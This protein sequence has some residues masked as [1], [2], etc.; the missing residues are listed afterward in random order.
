MRGGSIDQ[1]GGSIA[2]EKRGGCGRTSVR[3]L[4]KR[5]NLG[6]SVVMTA[7]RRFGPTA[8]GTRSYQRTV[9]D[10]VQSAQSLPSRQCPEHRIDHVTKQLGRWCLLIS[11]S[12][13]K[14]SI[15]NF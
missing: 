7:T 1:R 15:R 12:Q 14:F 8:F 5:F 3:G 9:S 13:S 2:A 4:E 10:T 6:K 11:L